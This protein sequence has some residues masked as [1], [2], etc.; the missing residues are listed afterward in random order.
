MNIV[1]K[2]MTVIW[3]LRRPDLYPQMGYLFY[4][5]VAP[6]KKENTREESTRWCSSVSISSTEAVRQLTGITSIRPLRE[7]FPGFFQKAAEIIKGLP[8]KMG[9]GADL[10]LLYYLSEHLKA[11]TAIETGVA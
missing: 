1:S 2:L 4:Q 9:G 6:H 8:V 3:F 11:K 5:R 7:L 10:E